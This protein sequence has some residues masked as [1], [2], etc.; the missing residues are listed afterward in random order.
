MIN[1]SIK[2]NNII[3]YTYF[4]N[5]RNSSCRSVK[6]SNNIIFLINTKNLSL[7]FDKII[8]LFFLAFYYAILAYL[9]IDTTP[10]INDDLR[11]SSFLF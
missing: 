4:N 3:R 9:K 7:K 5:N 6:F 2:K 11:Y 1:H 10:N 8:F